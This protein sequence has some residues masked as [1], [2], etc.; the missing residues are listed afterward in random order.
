MTKTLTPIQ[1]I[2][3][4]IQGF[5][6]LIYGGLPAGRSYL[7][8]GEPGTGKTIFSLQFLLEGLKNGESAIFISI[9]EKPDHIIADA[10][11]K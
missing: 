7:V 3:T 6:Q 11:A 1:R 9:D 8:S 2:Q 4:G 5:D 10:E